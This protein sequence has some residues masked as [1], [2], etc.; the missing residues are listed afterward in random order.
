MF[1]VAA[2]SWPPVAVN[3]PYLITSP[4]RKPLIAIRRMNGIIIQSPSSIKVISLCSGLFD[5]DQNIARIARG[6]FLLW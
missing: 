5:V 4:D 3:V 6:V 1:S 2:I